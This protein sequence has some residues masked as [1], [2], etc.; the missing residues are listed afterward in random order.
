MSVDPHSIVA[1]WKRRLV[2][3]ANHPPYVFR[4]T[5][6]DLIDRHRRN[7]TT[8][9]G[10]SLKEVAEAEERLDVRFPTVFRTYLL[11]MGKHRGEL[12]RGSDL[13][14]PA[15]FD[16][17]RAD[18]LALMAET[19]PTL[20]LPPDA[21]VFLFHQ[22]YTFVYLSAT[23]GFDGPPMQWTEG[24]RETKQ[25]ASTFADMVDAE[26]RGM[27]DLEHAQRASGGYYLTLRPDGRSTAVHPARNSREGPFKKR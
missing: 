19:D 4:D 3:M 22:G 14:G 15:A 18:A 17:F 1:E 27:E 16:I 7:L 2:E 5:P 13:A 25:I 26:L 10:Y 8:F 9:E 20:S 12:F 6:E 11:E 21:I 23:G 24:T